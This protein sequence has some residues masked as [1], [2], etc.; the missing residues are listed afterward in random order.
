MT[1]TEAI[2]GRLKEVTGVT[3]DGQLASY[4]GLSRQNIGAARKRNDV[5]SGWI[6][7]VAELT[8]CSMDWL[9]FGQG[10]KIRVE[11]TAAAVDHDGRIA[12]TQSAYGLQAGGETGPANEL[13]PDEKRSGFGAAVEMLAKIYSSGDDLLINTINANIRAFCEAIDRK[14]REQHSSKELVQLKE[15]LLTIEKKLQR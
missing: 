13:Q 10:S 1:E 4:L 7:K 2:I 14:H 9:R 8:G 3:S 12:T 11:Y 5:P 15:R 6:Y